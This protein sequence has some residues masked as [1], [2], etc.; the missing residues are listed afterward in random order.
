LDEHKPILE[1]VF[2]TLTSKHDLRY[3]V[4]TCCGVEN[5]VT[6]KPAWIKGNTTFDAIVNVAL[7]SLGFASTI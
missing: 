1:Q 2:V 7:D 6:L 4:E 3:G 5:G